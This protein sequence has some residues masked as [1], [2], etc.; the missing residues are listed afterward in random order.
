MKAY[1]YDGRQSREKAEKGSKNKGGER[2]LPTLLAKLKQEHPDEKFDSN[3]TLYV[4]EKGILYTGTYGGGTRIVGKAKGD[5]T[6]PPKSLPR[7][8]S[9]AGDFLRLPRGQERHGCRVRLLV[10]AYRVYPSGQSGPAC[11]TGQNRSLGRA[12]NEGDQ[13]DGTQRLDQ[14]A[15]SHRLA[16]RLVPVVSRPERSD[17]RKQGLGN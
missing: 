16:S 3:G 14:S 12:A 4:G 11:R 10:A 9:I 8:G 17:H 5:V 7:P 15:V 6:E 2:Y 13:S 1:W